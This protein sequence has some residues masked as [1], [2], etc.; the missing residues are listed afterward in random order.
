MLYPDFVAPR[1][2]FEY[3]NVAGYATEWP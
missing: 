1:L 2:N 3:A